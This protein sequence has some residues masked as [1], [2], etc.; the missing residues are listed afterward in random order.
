M[1]E[2]G[3]VEGGSG[4]FQKEGETLRKRVV[5]GQLGQVKGNQ[6][7]SC[8][9]SS[10]EISMRSANDFEG[11]RHD[12]AESGGPGESGRGGRRGGGDQRTEQVE[13]EGSGE[14]VLP[15]G[16]A[17]GVSEGEDGKVNCQRSKEYEETKK[18]LQRKLFENVKEV[19]AEYFKKSE[20]PSKVSVFT[21][22]LLPQLSIM[23]KSALDL[24]NDKDSTF[25]EEFKLFYEKE[26]QRSQTLEAMVKVQKEGMTKLMR[27]ENERRKHEEAVF[28]EQKELEKK[29]W[30]NYYN[31]TQKMYK[32]FESSTHKSSR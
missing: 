9:G 14:E 11:I 22:Q 15:E 2:R 32:E 3:G 31:V 26:K 16:H 1:G 25:L 8:F 27:E 29:K 19:Y 12:R 5:R 10:R 17:V 20:G 24:F 7:G 23:L 28:K 21:L 4:G 6:C 30:K 13:S 18:K